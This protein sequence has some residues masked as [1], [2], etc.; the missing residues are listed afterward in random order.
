MRGKTY[1]RHFGSVE[2]LYEQS[3]EIKVF[4]AMQNSGIIKCSDDTIAGQVK[5]RTLETAHLL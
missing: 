1:R 5:T 3:D 4:Q 2:E